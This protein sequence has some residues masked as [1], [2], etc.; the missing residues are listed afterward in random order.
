MY[1]LWISDPEFPELD[2][3]AKLLLLEDGLITSGD[4]RA[5]DLDGISSSFSIVPWTETKQKFI[6]VKYLE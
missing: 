5:F 4:D 3:I 2:E 1:F 6:Y